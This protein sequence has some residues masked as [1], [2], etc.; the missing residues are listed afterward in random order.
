MQQ[1]LFYRDTT[2]YAI[3]FTVDDI[4][5]IMIRSAQFLCQCIGKLNFEAVYAVSQNLP[6]ST[7]AFSRRWRGVSPIRY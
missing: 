4:R 5:R 6:D 3:Q 2:A 7:P 1:S